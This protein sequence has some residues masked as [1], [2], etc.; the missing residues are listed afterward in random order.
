MSLK[1]VS[2]ASSSKSRD[3][4]RLTKA[5]RR[6]IESAVFRGVEEL[7]SRLL[8]S[9]SV[10][11]YHNDPASTGQNLNETLLTPAN[12]NSNN[13]GKLF[14]TAVDGQIYAQPLQVAGVN[15]TAGPLPGTHNVV[16]VATMN[17]SL[18][19]MDASSGAILWQDSFR[20][21]EPGIGT[22]VS[23]TPV[24]N[25]DYNTGDV[26]P[27]Y[28][29]TSTPVIDAAAGYLYLVANTKQIV[30]G[31]TTSPHYVYTLNK[32]NLSSGAFTSTVIA[33]TIRNTSTGA[34]TYSTSPYVLDPAGN[35]AGVVT[36]NVNG[37]TQNVIY[38]DVLTQGQR[39][40]LTLHNGNV[41]IA[42][43]SHGDNP[44]YHGWI[45]GYNAT[46]LASS[47][48]FNVNPN[49]GY[50]GIWQGGGSLVF[51]PQGY[52]Y[53]ET[54]NGDFDSTLNAQGFP[55][56][57]D[58]GDSFVK[59]AI[60]S[61]STQASQNI[62]GWGLKVV[63]YF[64]P[65]NQAA[66]SSA[67]A[68]LGSGGTFVLPRTAGTLAIGNAAHPDLLI[69]A[70]KE[71]KIYLID[72][73]NMGKFSPVTDQVVQEIGGGLG[74][75]GSFST[76]SFFYD[77]TTARVYY[78]ASFD[79]LRAFTIANGVLS[80]PPTAGPD[81]LGYTGATASI[82]ANGTTNGIVWAL[83][84]NANQ[85]RAYNASNIAQEYYSSGQV[86]GRDALGNINKFTVPLVA[87]GL[88]Y[89]GTQAAL[90]GY[91]EL[92][93]P[94]IV[95]GAPTLLT[96]VKA[97]TVQINL[98]W[99]N[100]ANNASQ[101]FI[102]ESPDGGATWTQIAEA[103]ATATSYQ[104]FGLQPGSTYTF[105]VRAYNV[106][107]YSGYSNTAS[108]TTTAELP[109]PNFSGGFATP[110][111]ITINQATQFVGSTI[112]L[113]DSTINRSASAFFNNLVSVAGF[114]TSFSFQLSNPA[115]DG[116]T[117]TL[118]RVG[119]TARG[120]AGG[121][122]GYS[123]PYSD[124]GISSSIAI[125]F[126]LQ[127]DVGEGNNSTGLFV[128]GD[129]PTLP[130]GRYAAEA[131][132]D[133]TSS[134]VNLHSGDIMQVNLSYNGVTLSE[135]V[136]DTVTQATFTHNYA[137]NIPGLIGSTAAYVGFTGST[138][139]QAGT[140]S[141]L[142]WNFASTPALPNTP[143]SFT[144]T[145][146]SGT[147]LDLSWSDPFS[148]VTTYNILQLING[149]YTK[150][151]QV[152]GNVNL[153]QATGLSQGTTNSYEVVAVNSTGNSN[154]AGP[155][156]GT[157][158]TAPAA[159][160]ALQLQNLTTTSVTI[161]WTNNATNATGYRIVRQLESNN[162]QYLTT[163]P[164]TATSFTDTGLTP[165]R[166]YDYTIA[167]INL[168]GPSTGATI[169]VQTIPTAPTGMTTTAG[170]GQ[171]TISWAPQGHA[172]STYKVYRGTTPNGEGTTA[173]ATVAA[174]TYVDSPL[175][176]GKTYYYKIT[177]V[178]AP[179]PTAPAAAATPTAAP[180]VSTPPTAPALVAPA[181]S[182]TVIDGTA[183][184]PSFAGYLKSTSPLGT[185]GYTLSLSGF[186]APHAANHQTSPP[187]KLASH[188]APVKVKFTPAKKSG[189]SLLH[190]QD[191][192]AILRS[193]MSGT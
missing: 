192:I 137:V 65:S 86:A 43:A 163:L 149:S 5:G 4:R 57:G 104:V 50:D 69:G 164:A 121:G 92:A 47:A 189:G 95:P 31:N 148:S 51:D 66:L 21:A 7:E 84:K 102:E 80:T 101:Y 15:I 12:V 153:Y 23:V 165:G 77:G 113:T 178:D 85:L 74:G 27:V 130:T 89:V 115:A 135:T 190:S 44:P 191:P 170:S 147:E 158:P 40:A 87:N 10:T 127:N 175:T 154:G 24:P 145:P 38:L 46:T 151:G 62:N 61:A 114:N 117:F 2:T 146:T 36:A 79:A 20:V 174:T 155:V 107:G 14:S 76:A 93:P 55:I 124:G 129:S 34:L 110:T 29:I 19:A 54:G 139:D 161:N 188:P 96:A 90:V 141:I 26:N 98:S 173:I 82:S 171:A 97:S 185:G 150:I 152:P 125:K 166:A 162:S 143:V 109:P 183:W 63:D 99:H 177:A 78:G 120:F 45:L 8:L 172:V 60:D 187:I 56:N 179:A 184:S 17:D 75:G 22:P 112:R 70:G 13:F 132:I 159:A 169:N 167:A 100:N 30:N 71:G 9:V 118:Q 11:Q 182:K 181:P 33:D 156:S 136:T 18:Y 157:T 128:N 6:P 58:Y 1:S 68:D 176:P 16:Y 39:G 105:R 53:F 94:T 106:V 142:N 134:G 37:T 48:V 103:G 32:V 83:D 3:R 193:L 186:S 67:D 41:Y 73:N 108:A 131:S 138:D 116:I 160:T 91:G 28:G 111:G 72:R 49:G 81:N 180:T 64:A 140:Q 133:M 144:V 59:V 122:L 35:G 25:G 168:A 88:V 52:M 126:D 123:N 119:P 42:F